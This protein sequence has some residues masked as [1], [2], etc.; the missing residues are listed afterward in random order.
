MQLKTSNPPVRPIVA[1]LHREVDR[2]VRLVRDAHSDPAQWWSHRSAQIQSLFARERHGVR[3]AVF[4]K[5]K[6]LKMRKKPHTFSHPTQN[7]RCVC[8]TLHNFK[9]QKYVKSA[10]CQK[11]PKFEISP[12]T[13]TKTVS[14]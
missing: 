4:W 7:T 3:N 6:E 10:K 5:P 13:F 11:N 8:F 2:L 14:G 9:N 12:L 1:G